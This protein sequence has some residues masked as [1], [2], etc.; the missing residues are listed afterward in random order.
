MKNPCVIGLLGFAV[1]SALSARAAYAPTPTTDSGKDFTLSLTAGVT[2]DSNVFGSATRKIESNVY[3]LAPKAV[4][5]ASVTDQTFVTGSYQLSADYFD[6]RPGEKTLYSH[7]F[8][9]RVAH[10]FSPVTN[11]SFT[12]AFVVA[13]NPESL[14]AG[15]PINTDQSYQRNQ[16]DALFAT[17]PTK[18]TNVTVKARSIY[19]NYRSAPLGR[20][21]DRTENLYGLAGDFAVLPDVKAVGEYR[22]QDVA[23]RSSSDNKDKRSDFFLAGADYAAGPKLS[24]STRLGFEF[25]RRSG[26]RSDTSPYAEV[27]GK[28][29][30]ADRAFVSAGYVYTLEES[31]DVVR[32]TDTQVN[33][34]FVNVQH[35]VTA[36]I[37]A[38]GSLTYEPSQ[39]QGRRGQP[40][41]SETTTRLGAALTYVAAKNWSVAA[42]YDYDHINSDD[43]VRGQIRH[44]VGVSA[45]YAF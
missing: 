37:F 35:P 36:R 4:Y 20:S 23:Y 14:L 13:K 19:Y 25:R 44:R 24:A 31:S 5:A 29:D 42:S 6:N 7:D 16:F 12:D 8:F 34:F 22:H 21:L 33:R 45:T 1:L 3:H 27:S 43:A 39:L 32:F 2:R 10:A 9:A 38:S 17:A 18:K 26:E 15:I 28:Y 40:N 30:Y 41:L 11:I